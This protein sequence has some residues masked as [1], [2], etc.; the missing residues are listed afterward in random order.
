MRN[1]EEGLPLNFRRLKS[2]VNKMPSLRELLFDI[3]K[4]RN[5]S[6]IC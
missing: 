6:Y 1:L 5:M 3:D 2:T 4:L